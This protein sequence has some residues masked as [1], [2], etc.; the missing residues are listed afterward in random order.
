MF[1]TLP[2]L[3]KHTLLMPFTIYTTHVPKNKHYS[4]KK[5]KKYK[6]APEM[7]LNLLQKPEKLFL[8]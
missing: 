4:N 1:Q 8:K 2:F 7:L 6:S 3:R 5:L